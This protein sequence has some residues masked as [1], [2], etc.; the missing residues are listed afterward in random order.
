MKKIQSILSLLMALIFAGIGYLANYIPYRPSNIEIPQTDAFRLV[1]DLHLGWNLGNTLEAYSEWASGNATETCWGNPYTTREMIGAVKDAGFCTVR[2]PVTWHGH[3]GDA[4]DYTVDSDWMDRVQEVVDYAYSQNLYVILNIHHDDPYWMIP[5][6]DKEQETT[7]QFVRLWQQIAE[8]FASYGEKLLFEA[9]NEPRVVGSF[10]EWMGGLAQERAVLNR[11]NAAFVET[12]RA[13]GGNHAQ[14][15][16]LVPTYAASGDFIA[17]RGMEVPAD[18]RVI[19][20]VHS[21]YPNNFVGDGGNAQWTEGYRWLLE[22]K[23]ADIYKTFVAK[24]I[25]VYLGEFGAVHKNN[26]ADRVAYVT[27]Y[28][29]IAKKYGMTCGWWDNGYNPSPESSDN[30]Y[31]LLDR[32]TCT[33]LYPEIVEAMVEAAG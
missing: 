21:Y 30:T 32:S 17:L 5:S 8:R 14:R 6:A 13:A 23:L 11:L 1:Q 19:V 18:E 9:A 28:I 15:Y 4:P 2:I 12:I 27:D 31:A 29:S 24:G 25:P 26:T 10:T 22:N 20:S 16:L 33:W 3:M 7:Q